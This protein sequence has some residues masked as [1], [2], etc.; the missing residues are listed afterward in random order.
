MVSVVGRVMSYDVPS[1]FLQGMHEVWLCFLAES[2]G[3][4][5]LEDCK[6]LVRIA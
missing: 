2:V 6:S 4:F 5:V 3:G 1:G